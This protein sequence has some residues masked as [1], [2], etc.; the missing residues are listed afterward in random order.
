MK[1]NESGRVNNIQSYQRNIESRDMHSIEKKKSR[2]DELSISSEAL[3]LSAQIHKVQD[4]ARAD[5]IQKLKDA[6]SSGTYEVPAD[7]LAEKLAPYFK[8]FNRSGDSK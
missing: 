8:G 4:P 3:E 6:V 7:R 2:K 1:I 5:K